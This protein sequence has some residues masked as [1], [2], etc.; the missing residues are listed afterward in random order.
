M[1]MHFET[2]SWFMLFLSGC[3]FGGFLLSQLFY[4]MLLLN[5]ILMSCRPYGSWG[6]IVGIRARFQHSNWWNHKPTLMKLTFGRFIQRG[7]NHLW[8]NG[9]HSPVHIWIAEVVVHA[10]NELSEQAGAERIDHI[11]VLTQL[12]LRNSQLWVSPHWEQ[13]NGPQ[14]TMPENRKGPLCSLMCKQI[15]RMHHYQLVGF[16]MCKL[17]SRMHS[18][19]HH[20][21]V[22]PPCNQMCNRT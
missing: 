7:H 19:L 1:L 16:L 21:L 13:T 6:V 14:P 20:H 4:S 2:I 11:W 12:Y 3:R 5:K 17:I 15:S 22:W 9:I 10:D 8:S 18:L